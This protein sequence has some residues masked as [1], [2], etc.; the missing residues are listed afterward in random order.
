MT[1]DAGLTASSYDEILQLDQLENLTRK[2]V[3]GILCREGEELKIK[4]SRP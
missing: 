2:K 1:K 4:S 3:L